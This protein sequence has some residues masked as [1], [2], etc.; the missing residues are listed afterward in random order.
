MQQS[1]VTIFYFE[2]FTMSDETIIQHLKDKELHLLN[3]LNKVRA[4][5]K[6][7]IEDNIGFNNPERAE[8]IGNDIPTQYDKSLT[9]GN[10]VRFILAKEGKPLLVDEIVAA[11]HQL[12]PELDIDKMHK[13]VSYNLSMLVRYAKVKKHP[14]QRKVKYA[15]I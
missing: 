8:N 10:K 4:A 6:A 5:L 9:Y 11:L 13:N 14:F 3:E 15:G 2:Q 7:F 1:C 12:E